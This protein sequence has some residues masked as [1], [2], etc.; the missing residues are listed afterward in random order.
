MTTGNISH[1]TVLLGTASDAVTTFAFLH[2]MRTFSRRVQFE[3]FASVMREQGEG[4]VEDGAQ[5][6]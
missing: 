3:K 2:F 5:G 1:G 6:L 4:H